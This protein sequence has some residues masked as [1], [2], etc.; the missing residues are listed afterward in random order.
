MAG[1]LGKEGLGF[2]IRVAQGERERRGVEV[3]GGGLEVGQAHCGKLEWEGKGYRFMS[4]LGAEWSFVSLP[5]PP[6]L[7]S[8]EEDG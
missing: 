6:E 1:E 7:E 4:S 2:G 5:L 3:D 8:G